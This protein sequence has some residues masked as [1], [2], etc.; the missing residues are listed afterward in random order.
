MGSV[1]WSANIGL[2][3]TIH[4]DL[5]VFCRTSYQIRQHMTVVTTTTVVV[6]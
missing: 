1:V 6:I 3:Q 4:V 5:S 2:F